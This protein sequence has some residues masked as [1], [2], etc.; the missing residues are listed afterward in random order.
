[1]NDLENLCLEI[2]KPNSKPFVVIM[3]Y[4][5][6]NS[7]NEIFTSLENLIGRLDSE[8]VEF[9]LMG[10]MSCNMA[11]MSDTNSHL[12][13]DIMDVYGLQ[14]M[15]NEPT[16][17]TDMTS[18]LIDLI[19]TNCP[20]KVISS[21]VCH[22]SI[23]DHSVIYIYR[24]LAIGA[25]PKGR[26]TIMYRNFKNFNCDRFRSDIASINWNYQMCS[27]AHLTTTNKVVAH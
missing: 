10:D 1:M 13:S 19:Y 9:N 22:V 2:R 3:W 4:R 20:D 14:Q 11:S 6:P 15:I 27:D 23:S 25:V 26:N 8:N 24:K 18:T 12:L 16:R 17:I 5:P 21:G 7:T